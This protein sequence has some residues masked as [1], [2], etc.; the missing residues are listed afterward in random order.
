MP[1]TAQS[2]AQDLLTASA[3]AMAEVQ[4]FH[5]VITTDNGKI[6]ILDK[7]E[8]QKA[9]GD[10]RQPHTMKA[11]ISGKVKILP[12]TANVIVIG[13]DIWAAV[14]PKADKYSKLDPTK[15]EHLEMVT[16]FDPTTVLLKAIDYVQDPTITGTEELDGISTTIVEGKVDVS[17]LSAG[18]TPVAG[19]AQEPVTAR[20]WI[21]SSNLVQRLQIVGP[22]LDSEPEEIVHQLDLSN[23]NAPV[24]IV[25]P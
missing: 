8:F 25:A 18:G 9:E 21:D 5:F 3:T 10:V 7:F 12:V 13:S 1:A 23:Y 14:T 20:I 4:S 15:I 19:M 6:V 2:S 24:D 16:E 17:Q 22:I 11:S